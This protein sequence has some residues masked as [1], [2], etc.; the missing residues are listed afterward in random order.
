MA[1]F[2]SFL[3]LWLASWT[4]GPLPPAVITPLTDSIYVHTTY[5][6]YGGKPFPSN[7]L[8]VRTSA[9]VVLVDTGWGKD[10]TR[11]IL[12]WVRRHLRQ[13][14]VLCLATHAH[15]DRVGGAPVLKRKNIPVWTSPSIA[16]KAAAQGYAG[17]EGR[18]SAD[19]VLTVGAT[20]FHAFFPGAGHSEDNV[21]V[22]LP[23]SRV[24]FGGCLVK[25]T[26]AGGLGN[27]ADANLEEWGK[28]IRRLQNKF[29]D[30]AVV[31]PGHQAWGGA[32]ALQHTLDLLDKH[33]AGR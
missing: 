21:V 32:A 6:L 15:D 9:G 10:Q 25:S 3:S 18:L 23:R 26:E 2:I 22:W 1:A 27:I 16:E 19:T 30:P 4:D 33:A 14:V 29:P 17:V 11:E 8:I 24:L 28:T 12:R 13:K 7:G 31:V 5:Q 20:R